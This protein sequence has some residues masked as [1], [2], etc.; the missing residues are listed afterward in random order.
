M[1]RYGI[2]L[3]V[4]VPLAAVATVCAAQ[5]QA[6]DRS[7]PDRIVRAAVEGVIGT[8]Q[9]DPDTRSGDL[10]KITAVVERQFLPYADFE[11]T[12]RLAVGSAWSNASPE[13]KKQLH[14]QFQ[15]LLVRSYAVSLSQLR[16]KNVKFRYKPVLAASGATDVVVETRVLNNG[17]EMQIDYRLQRI[18]NGWKIYDINMLG[19]W[20]IEVY[21]RQFADIVA[22]NGIDGLLKYLANHN[23][24]RT[25]DT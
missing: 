3:Q 23:A 25:A 15:T 8:I 7:S 19:A 16:E 9:S 12:T 24:R 4:L 18:G 17:D 5:A 13:Q 1:K 21:R 22:R 6:L 20:L 11:R 10:A 2:A 14:E